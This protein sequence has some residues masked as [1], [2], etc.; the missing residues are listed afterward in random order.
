MNNFLDAFGINAMEDAPPRLSPASSGAAP[1]TRRWSALCISF[2][3]GLI[4]AFAVSSLW[5]SADVCS[6]GLNVA[7]EKNPIYLHVY[8]TMVS[9][10]HDDQRP[11]NSPLGPDDRPWTRIA[12]V[13]VYPGRPFGFKTPNERRPSIAIDGLLTAEA[14]GK[15]RGRIHFRLDDSNLTYD[16]SEEFVL[17]VDT[18][19]FFDQFYDCFQ[20]SRSEDPYSTL[21]EALQHEGTL[22]NRG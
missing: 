11:D 2:I 5:H 16:I 10:D 8:G 14:D 1:S 9:A 20:I 17:R 3:L 22:E 12:A 6:S 13:H 18:V 19:E 7:L 15:Y 4:C 21:K